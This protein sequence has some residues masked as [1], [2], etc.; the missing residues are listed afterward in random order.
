MFSHFD[1]LEC[2]A[3]LQT[4]APTTLINFVRVERHSRSLSAG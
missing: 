3:C 4:Y 1:H 2:S